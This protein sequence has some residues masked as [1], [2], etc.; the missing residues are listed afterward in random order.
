MMTLLLLVVVIMTLWDRIPAWQAQR[1]YTRWQNERRAML[2]RV[3][4]LDKGQ[5]ACCVD[6]RGRMYLAPGGIE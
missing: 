4:D 2:L 1:K 3:Y 6:D 5:G